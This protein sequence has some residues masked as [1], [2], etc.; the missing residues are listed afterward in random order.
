MIQL[1]FR[2]AELNDLNPIRELFKASVLNI[3]DEYYTSAQRNEWSKTYDNINR[4]EKAIQDQYFLLALKENHLIG[5][6]TLKENEY[7]DFIY[8]HPD[9]L[10]CGIAQKLLN[11][12]QEKAIQQ[13]A[14]LLRSDVSKA[15]IG[16]F[17]KNGFQ[18]L[19]ENQ[20]KRDEEVLINYSVSKD[21][22]ENNLH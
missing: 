19:R 12:I 2:E 14:V 21:L 18:V 1:L 17:E 4:W 20:N 13:R 10:G 15:A 22:V 9:H 8:V 6:I 3:S 11:K 7:I 16:F 5:F